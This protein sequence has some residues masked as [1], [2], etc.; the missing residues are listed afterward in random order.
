MSLALGVD[1]S[2]T[3]TKAVLQDAGGTVKAVGSFEYRYETPHPLWSEQDPALWWEATGV[4]IRT[5]LEEAGVD[6]AAVEA[7][8]LTGQMHGLVALD[9]R[10]EVLRPAIL[11]NDQR[12]QAE[13]DLIRELVGRERLI[14]TTGNDALTGFTAPKL[15]WLR[16]NEPEVW[17]SIAHVLLP[18][19]LVRLR[20]TG[21]H[22][23]DK[24]DG[25][26]TILFDLAARDWSAEIVE[27]LGIEARWLPQTYEGPAVTGAI[28]E[29]AA[30]ATGLRSGTPVIAGGG[31]QAAAAVGLGSVVPG[32]W[33]MSV[34]T[35]GV[36]FATTDGPVVEPE[37][38]LHAFCHA[39]PDRWH[40]MGVMLS[41]AGSLRWY[42]D[43]FAPG[44]AF[45]ELVEDAAQAPPGS[46]GLLFLPYLTGE[47]TP[48]PDP[49]ARGAF[50]GL[51]VNHGRA[52]VTRAVLEG[53]AF[54]MRDM[55][56][57]MAAAGLPPASEIRATGG[58]IRSE[59][60]R[61]ILADVLGAAIATTSTAEGAAQGAA[62]LA[63]VGVGWFDTVEDACRE[64]VRVDD[65]TEPSVAAGMYE[66]PYHRY[67]ELYPALAPT[68][69]ATG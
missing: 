28:T 67:R 63:A 11:W 7:V 4:A 24:A 33:S 60:W 46:D 41:A 30:A 40:L 5:A 21:E 31:D 19:D 55:L 48:H 59:L 12:T 43:A 17:G 9:D 34:G 42:R 2:T 32:V 23:M 53:V 35:S 14:A 6:G 64:L 27:A 68:F 25:S 52:H 39:V 15:L 56:G 65:R 58:G 20:L 1:V 37:G 36:L 26:G 66:Q 50:V 54:G 3:A 22:A 62:T 57:L 51:T 18:K 13:C 69:H 8:G 49:L 44:V 10:D 29:A 45:G 47:R 61:Q 38:R 16:R